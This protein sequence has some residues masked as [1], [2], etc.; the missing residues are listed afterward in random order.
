MRRVNGFVC[1]EG[2]SAIDGEP[3]AV[4]VIGIATPSTNTKTGGMLQSY[5][6]RTDCTPLD[7]IRMGVDT[8]ICGDCVHRSVASGGQGSCYVNV[9]QGPRAVVDAYWRGKYP[10]LSLFDAARVVATHGGK[11]RI[12]TYGDPGA[13]PDAGAFWSLL[14][15]GVPVDA[16]GEPQRTGYTHRWRDT[17]ASLRGLVMASTDSPADVDAARAGG[18]S[19]F[20]VSACGDKTRLPDEAFCPA[21]AEAGRRVTCEGCPI[22]CNGLATVRGRVIQAHGSTRNRVTA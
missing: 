16:K 20:R 1:Y 22:K 19:W 12:G 18:W 9:G 21:S 15:V 8:S 13:V 7:A 6:V 4:I 11:F 5:I 3:I 2:P 17:G 14:T 10:R